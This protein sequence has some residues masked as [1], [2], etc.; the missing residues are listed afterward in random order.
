MQHR[1]GGVALVLRRADACAR[2]GQAAV[3]AE[4]GRQRSASAPPALVADVQVTDLTVDR[5]A[6]FERLLGG[7]AAAG[8]DP[9]S[10]FDWDGS[11][12]PYPGLL[13]FQKAD[14]AVYFGRDSAIRSLLE[15]LARQRR[16]GGARWVLLLGASGSGKSSLVRAGIAPRL[17]RDSAAW[18]VAPPLRPL[19]RPL[20]SLALALA[21][22]P[23]APPWAAIH[24]ALQ[25]DAQAAVPNAWRA[26]VN[27][28]RSS[29]GGDTG[30]LLVVDQL[31]EALAT[32]GADPA[33]EAGTSCACC[34]R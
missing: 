7:L 4:D 29:A 22:L 1:G 18:R 13:A 8:L 24:A 2:A 25:S 28:V 19:A 21:A 10:L 9:A 6:G 14:A 3:P 31:E 26:A 16:T 5:E 15:T 32:G 34:A 33:A 17:E 12:P 27:D 11:R 30:V 20:E 23:G